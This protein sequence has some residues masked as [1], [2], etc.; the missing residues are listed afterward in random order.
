MTAP[1]SLVPPENANRADTLA[2]IVRFKGFAARRR[3][4]VVIQHAPGVFATAPAFP[5]CLDRSRRTDTHGSS[6][7]GAAQGTRPVSADAEVAGAIWAG[8]DGPS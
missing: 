4:C 8:A 6:D 1:I 3:A 2:S 5:A 7:S